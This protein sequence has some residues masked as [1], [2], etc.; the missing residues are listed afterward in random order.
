MRGIGPIGLTE[1]DRRI[2]SFAPQIEG[3]RAG[4]KIDHQVRKARRKVGQARCQP[5]HA[6]TR[7]RSNIQFPATCPV[8]DLFR[9]LS[10]PVERRTHLIQIGA[11]S[12]IEHNP[13][14]VA[15]KQPGLQPVLE[16][17]NLATDRAL[18]QPNLFAGPRKTAIARRSDK[19]VESTDRRQGFPAFV[20]SISL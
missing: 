8:N 13:P 1:M 5:S 2:K 16:K 7:E 15:V 19:A 12:R 9:R 3:K 6:E 14:A 11:A 17:R 18:R 4:C 10:D 20:H